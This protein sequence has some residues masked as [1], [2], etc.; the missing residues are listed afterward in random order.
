M[1]G[2]SAFDVVTILKKGRHEVAGCTVAISAERAETDPKV[3]TRIH[4]AFT[5]TGRK[6]KTEAVERAVKLSKEKYCSASIM[7]GQ[8]ATITHDV[9]VGDDADQPK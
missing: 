9:V 2:C 5:V 4:M 1:G 6:L 8:T 7:I 3:F